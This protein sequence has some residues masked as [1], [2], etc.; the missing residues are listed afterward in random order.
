MLHEKCDK[1]KSEP[2]ELVSI[3]TYSFE[4][5]M[6]MSQELIKR[7]NFKKKFRVVLEHDPEKPSIDVRYFI[8]ET[9]PEKCDCRNKE[10]AAQELPSDKE[11]PGGGTIEEK[12]REKTL[13]RK[14]RHC[15][16]FFDHDEIC[17]CRKEG[18]SMKKILR[19]TY[20]SGSVYEYT[21]AKKKWTPEDTCVD[22]GA[23]YEIPRR[24][25]YLRI[26][27]TNLAVTS[28]LKDVYTYAAEPNIKVEWV[29]A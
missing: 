26:D 21:P 4:C 24:S 23:Y 12:E 20:P 14:C 18:N 8:D 22:Y 7:M 1:C 2:D 3:K 28:N 9:P 11:N 15:G 13:Q 10:T 19:L 5:L 29:F 27:K 25:H 16:S 6:I 17:D